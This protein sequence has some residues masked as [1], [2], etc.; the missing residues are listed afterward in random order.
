MARWAG[1]WRLHCEEWCELPF[2]LRHE[3]FRCVVSD[4]ISFDE[5]IEVLKRSDLFCGTLR[6]PPVRGTIDP[7]A[8][9]PRLL[10]INEALDQELRYEVLLHEVSVP[11]APNAEWI[12]AML[13]SHAEHALCTA[14][15][16]PR[17]GGRSS[18]A[19]KRLFRRGTYCI[20]PRRADV[21]ATNISAGSFSSAFAIRSVRRAQ[22][23]RYSSGQGRPT[24]RA[25]LAIELAPSGARGGARRI[26]EG[27]PRAF[28][29][30]WTCARIFHD[31]VRRPRPHDR[32]GDPD[33]TGRVFAAEHGQRA[34]GSGQ[35]AGRRISCP[36]F[37]ARCPLLTASTLNS[38]RS[39]PGRSCRC[40]SP[41]RTPRAFRLRR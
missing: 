2:N 23:G 12:A 11:G 16:S 35:R 10:L 36:L 1:E 15:R 24:R 14:I 34:A 30:H 37:A 21:N 38:P 17:S 7:H 27:F 33:D 4:A 9:I 5:R 19:R 31:E 18:S 39:T 25:A 13:R 22:S 8:T 41:L 32:A 20:L 40:R 26:G 3:V 6:P 29:T 28:V